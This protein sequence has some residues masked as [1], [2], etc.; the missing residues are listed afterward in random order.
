MHDAY[1]QYGNNF[2]IEQM[3]ASYILSS[4]THTPTIINIFNKLALVFHAWL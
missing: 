2:E 3:Y 1:G 4:H